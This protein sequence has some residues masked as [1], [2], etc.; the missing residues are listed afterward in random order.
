M[1]LNE[2][3]TGTA[4]SGVMGRTG[5][6]SEPAWRSSRS[7]ANAAIRLSWSTLTGLAKTTAPWPSPMAFVSETGIS[8]CLVKQPQA[9]RSTHLYGVG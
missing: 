6:E 3:K 1:A 8:H 7:E 5:E 2:Y 4:F 9:G